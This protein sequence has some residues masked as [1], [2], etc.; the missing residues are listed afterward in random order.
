MDNEFGFGDGARECVLKLDG[1]RGSPE[2]YRGRSRELSRDSSAVSSESCFRGVLAKNGER[3]F[4]LISYLSWSWFGCMTFSL[5]LHFMSNLYFFSVSNTHQSYHIILYSLFLTPFMLCSSSVRQWIGDRH[6]FLLVLLSV[7][8]FIPYFI[9]MHILW[10]TLLCGIGVSSLVI[11]Q[12]ERIICPSKKDRN[13]SLWCLISGSFMLLIVRYSWYSLNPLFHDPEY[14]AIA[15]FLSIFC[16]IA[17]WFEDVSNTPRVE[18]SYSPLIADHSDQSFKEE[19]KLYLS[20][21]NDIDEADELSLD[22]HGWKVH[23]PSICAG[24]CFGAAIFIFHMIYT[25]YTI[26]PRWAGLEPFP[27]ALAPLACLLI[28][29]VLGTS[30]ALHSLVSWC[31]L[32][33]SIGLLCFGTGSFSL[34]GGCMMSL[35]IPPSLFS[36][37]G[38][39][40]E[41]K[42]HIFII[43]EV[44]THLSLTLIS[45]FSLDPFFRNLVFFSRPWIPLFIS[46][47]CIGMHVAS[48][49]VHQGQILPRGTSQALFLF[50]F[51]PISIF[52]PL[53]LLFS[54]GILPSTMMRANG[55]VPPPPSQNLIPLRPPIGMTQS[56]ETNTTVNPWDNIVP[57]K[58]FSVVQM[59][60]HQGYNNKGLTN[61]YHILGSIKEFRPQPAIVGLQ[62]VETNNMWTGAVDIVEFLSWNLHM[63]SVYGSNPRDSALGSALLTRYRIQNYST[64]CTSAKAKISSS[65]VSASV[66]FINRTEL[67]PLDIFVTQINQHEEAMHISESI[68]LAQE[69]STLPADHA[70]LWLGDIRF[71]RESSLPMLLLQQLNYVSCQG[72]RDEVNASGSEY[73]FFRNLEVN[74]T[75]CGTS[76]VAFHAPIFT[77]FTF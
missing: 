23:L 22:E 17:I 2:E 69:I 9:E 72:V 34:F 62:E 61:P 65:C 45:R 7:V 1:A 55:K 63:H 64:S 57:P 40:K 70:V 31:L 53:F 21:A 10:S 30:L 58:P 27:Y 8:A 32:M 26:I 74:S 24:T 39:L 47:F 48:K 75:S 33:I 12:N 77:T 71:H 68:L 4:S 52:L 60:I 44:F 29:T 66:S 15:L 5:S 56:N 43:A 73:Q 14:T 51:P 54:V 20:F 76:K 16:A 50:T 13:A 3:L 59:N 36:S 6:R 67:A 42:V 41:D 37:I 46:G 35:F 49:P 25:S 11:V 18:P 38:D 19:K 28:G